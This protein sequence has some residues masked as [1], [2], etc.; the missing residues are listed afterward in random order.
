[1]EEEEH[2]QRPDAAGHPLALPLAGDTVEDM[3][4]STTL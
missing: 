1:M 4:S 2:L 3:P